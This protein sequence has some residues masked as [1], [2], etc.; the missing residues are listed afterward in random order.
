MDQNRAGDS[1]VFDPVMDV[2]LEADL[3]A[4]SAGIAGVDQDLLPQPRPATDAIPLADV[5]VGPD[6]MLGTVATGDADGTPGL[7]AVLGRSQH[8]PW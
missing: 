5:V 4:I 7:R 1:I 2:E 3:A 8:R 6:A